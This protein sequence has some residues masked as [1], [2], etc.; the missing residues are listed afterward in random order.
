MRER[1]LQSNLSSNGQF[2]IHQAKSTS[3]RMGPSQRH[4]RRR[5]TEQNMCGSKCIVSLRKLL[6]NIINNGLNFNITLQYR[7]KCSTLVY[8]Q[9][10]VIAH[11]I[12]YNTQIKTTFR[13]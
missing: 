1:S 8:D 10:N 4:R 2:N 9:E 5:Q 3:T 7:Q 11:M 12:S 13:K 6:D